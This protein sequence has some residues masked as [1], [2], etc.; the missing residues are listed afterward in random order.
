MQMFENFGRI[1]IC[2][3]SSLLMFPAFGA[4]DSLE[5]A[6]DTAE[7]FLYG[8]QSENEALMR[9][10]SDPE[11][12]EAMA[13]ERAENQG[14]PNE[15]VTVEKVEITDI[16]GNRATARATYKTKHKKGRKH[17]DIQLIRVDGKWEVTT[18]PES[19][20]E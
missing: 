8:Q 16:E 2:L 9:Y 12:Y 7:V 14:K 18:P 17:E 6:A 19:G 5:E 15:N 11:Q 13:K 1:S 4:Q 20:G 3:A 10:V